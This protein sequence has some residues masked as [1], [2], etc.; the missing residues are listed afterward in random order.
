MNIYGITDVG[1]VRSTNQDQFICETL[2]E[3]T[4]VICVC[5]GMGGEQGGEIASKY[6]IETFVH[7]IKTDI[8][9]N[10]D[11]DGITAM[12]R[13]AVEYANNYVYQIGLSD[14]KLSKM[15]T[16][17]VGGL[18]IG[19]S[20][21]VANIGDSRC[22]H[23]GARGITQVTRDHSIVQEIMENTDV[24]T[25][26]THLE[27]LKKYLTRAIGHSTGDDCDIYKVN[28]LEG[29]SILLCSDGLHNLVI[30]E[31][32]CEVCQSMLTI[33]SKCEL[34]VETANKNGGND[35]ITVLLLE[36]GKEV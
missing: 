29:D 34:L 14:E 7:H 30:D 25:I 21:Y 22:Y 3:N 13:R 17:L 27:P 18:V 5:D 15:G 8:F 9:D 2:N 12:L 31:H 32:I 16:T 33:K 11:Q 24:S 23:I 28:L 20:F 4:A 19:N 26:E 10:I 35:N 6:A 36:Y 1:S